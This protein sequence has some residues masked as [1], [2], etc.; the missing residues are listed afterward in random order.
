[1]PFITHLI[2]SLSDYIFNDQVAQAGFETGHI[3]ISMFLA[4]LFI[5]LYLLKSLGNF[6]LVHACKNI[7]ICKSR[8]ETSKEQLKELPGELIRLFIELYLDINVCGSIEILMR[9]VITT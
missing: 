6:V 5:A 7:G 3:L 2:K 1:M 8:V 9:Q 4:F